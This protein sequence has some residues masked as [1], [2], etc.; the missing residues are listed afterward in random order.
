ETTGV[1]HRWRSVLFAPGNQPALVAKLRRARPDVAVLDLEDAVPAAAKADARP[2]AR[3]GV[4]ALAAP[5]GPDEAPPPAVWL[6]VNPVRSEWF[7]GDVEG[8]AALEGAGLAGIVVPKLETAS[9][10]QL[11]AAVVAGTGLGLLAGIE[12]ARG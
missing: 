8:L 1:A 10:L 5:P 11:A 4:A 2:I 6:R 9:D 3:G 12:T 7:A